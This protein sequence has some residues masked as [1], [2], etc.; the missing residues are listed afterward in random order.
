MEFP[1]RGFRPRQSFGFEAKPSDRPFRSCR[2]G[3]TSGHIARVR[4]Q[5]NNDSGSKPIQHVVVVVLLIFVIVVVV[6]V[7]VVV[8]VS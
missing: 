5:K 2:L 4:D 1:W 3:G 6:V 7:V 8:A